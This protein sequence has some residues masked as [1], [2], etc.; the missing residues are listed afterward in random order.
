MYESGINEFIEYMTESLH[1]PDSMGSKK[2]V[3]PGYIDD[4]CWAATFGKMIEVIKFMMARVPACG[5][6]FNMKKCIYLM[7]P[8]TERL[9]YESLRPRVQLLTSLGIPFENIKIHPDCQRDVCA[10]LTTRR[11]A[12]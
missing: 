8:T 6:R 4:L 7:A 5:Y 11:R 12:E 3:I 10:D 1:V 9:D 2:K